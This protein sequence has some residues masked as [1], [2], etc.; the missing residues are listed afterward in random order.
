LLRGLIGALPSSGSRTPTDGKIDSV[1]NEVWDYSV[2]AYT[3]AGLHVIDI[4][5]SGK[6]SIIESNLTIKGDAGD[7][8]IFRFSS[9][10]Q[11]ME[12]SESNLLLDGGIGIN[13]VLWYVDA[14][15]G[16]QSFN[17]SDATFYGMSLWDI[18]AD[19]DNYITLSNVEFCGQVISDRVDFSNTSGSACTFD[20]SAIPIPAAVWLFG[21]GL[22]GL[23]GIARRKKA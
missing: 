5:T 14:K 18:G 11:A 20:T 23:V 1:A 21:S 9:L 22:I 13:N 3:G 17:F 8:I 4:N 15:Q 6:F 10:D 19:P 16:V 2:G 7:T 12:V